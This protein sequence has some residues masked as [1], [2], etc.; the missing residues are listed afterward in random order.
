M[1]WWELWTHDPD[2]QT[3]GPTRYISMRSRYLCSVRADVVASKPTSVKKRTPR[4]QTQASKGQGR[5]VLFFGSH[6][7]LQLPT[8]YTFFTKALGL[9]D[10]EI[11]ALLVPIFADKL[12]HRI[13]A[14]MIDD[15]RERRY[16]FCLVD[17]SC[18]FVR[19]CLVAFLVVHLDIKFKIAGSARGSSDVVYPF[20]FSLFFLG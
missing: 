9:S 10:E 13:G 3:R 20:C 16:I 17:T 5:K 15:A 1:V 6:L 18:R 14:K 19:L 11:H 4:G 8:T 12:D 7:L 2:P